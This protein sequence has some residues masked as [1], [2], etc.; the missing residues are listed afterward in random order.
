VIKLT[1]GDWYK[2]FG[3]F[4]KFRIIFGE[5]ALPFDITWKRIPF[6]S[7]CKAMFI[8]YRTV[9]DGNMV[10]PAIDPEGDAWGE[11]DYFAQKQSHRVYLFVLNDR[12]NPI[13]VH[14]D[15]VINF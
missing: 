15:D 6:E 4:E 1:M 7:P 11:P 10:S 13:Y 14:P 8:G 12:Q 9:F 3:K 2:I 5:E